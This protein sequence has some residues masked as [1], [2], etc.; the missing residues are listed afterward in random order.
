[1]RKTNKLCVAL[2]LFGL[3]TSGC[4]LMPTAGS[5]R[6]KKSSAE[7]QEVVDNF[8]AKTH[9][10]YELYLANGG[11]LTYEEWLE[12]IKGEKGDKGDKGDRG[13]TGA[14]GQNG[15]KGDQGNPGQDGTT[16]HIGTNGNW[17]IGEQDT[18]VAA[19]GAQGVGISSI[20]FN[21]ENELIVT[22]DNGQIV[23]LGSISSS[24][25]QHEYECVSEPATC[26]VDGYFQFTC[27]TCGHIETV[28]DKAQGHTFDAYREKVPAT[29]MNDG[30]KSRRCVICGEEQT[31]VIPAHDHNFSDECM[32]D[33]EK[34]W[35]Y[36][37]TC[38]IISEEANHVFS[39]NSCTACAYTKSTSSGLSS[40]GLIFGLNDDGASYSIVTYGTY[41]E[42]TLDIPETYN[43]LPVT[44]I[45]SRAFKGGSFT[46]I[47]MPN[48]ITTIGDSAF[49]SCSNLTS[50]NISTGLEYIP[51]S[52][53]ASTKLNT[54]IIPEGVKTIG[55][56]AFYNCT[57]LEY[58]TISNTVNR[59]EGSCFACCT[60][61]E[62]V[63]IPSS[64][65]S[66]GGSAFSSCSALKNVVI[67]SSVT[68]IGNYAFSSCSSLTGII[69]PSSIKTINE[70]TFQ[71][72]SS[73]TNVV[74]SYGLKDINNR[75]FS[76]CSS[77]TS[78]TLP[79]SLHGIAVNCFR[80]CTKLTSVI[81][82]NTEGWYNNEENVYKE[83]LQSP[84][85]ACQQM[86][87]SDNGDYYGNYWTCKLVATNVYSVGGVSLSVGGTK[88]LSTMILPD[89][90][91][92]QITFTSSNE[93]VATV[94]STGKVTAIGNGSATITVE[95]AGLT[96]PVD[97]VVG[98]KLY[99]LNTSTC[100]SS[101]R[102]NESSYQI[103][104]NGVTWFN[105]GR[106][107]KGN[108]W[109][110]VNA[111]YF[112]SVSSRIENTTAINNVSKIMVSYLRDWGNTTYLNASSYE[113][114]L[115]IYEGK[116]RDSLT[117]ISCN[118]EI[119]L[120]EQ[121]AYTVY[122]GKYVQKISLTYDVSE[123]CCF[124]AFEPQVD[125]Y[126]YVIQEIAF[127]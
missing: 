47:T 14:T 4:S 27:K 89:T 79:S 94:D 73:L 26:T 18:G 29:C 121:T 54:V 10:I 51:S 35:H 92:S 75:A 21:G 77:L 69:I 20:A 68:S 36:C 64:V 95:S 41:S 34:H 78:I 49:Q 108:F 32:F 5:R 53:F 46:S 119:I 3:L 28:V 22:F 7:S 86:K 81:F 60:K 1:M 24:I 59:L 116:D 124:F 42:S 112:E 120:T 12:S 50:I 74:L 103:T 33:A 15:Q 123:G 43:G 17:W 23:N 104:A 72:C 87:N 125:W 45:L 91:T 93:A 25:H 9:E 107:Y 82:E 48:T 56:S 63:V 80:N 90:A 100:S 83:V 97:V 65:K 85:L 44:G 88:V 101:W 115:R 58:L 66:I 110:N 71:S 19:S 13:D 57:S 31:E 38:G 62:S 114:S 55:D 37:L 109:N 70:Y 8:D 98:N 30:V 2:L 67:P 39:G 126:D 96:T 117:T 6:S 105:S 122:E 102:W 52:C 84:E 61:L 16:P 113:A 118:Q 127:F 11:T 40:D 111:L 99:A 106:F 76:G